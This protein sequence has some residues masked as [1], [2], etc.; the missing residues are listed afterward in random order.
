MSQC[1]H[2]P[3]P[4][5]YHRWPVFTLWCCSLPLCKLALK[6]STKVC[7]WGLRVIHSILHIY[8]ILTLEHR[9]FSCLWEYQWLLID[10]INSRHIKS[11]CNPNITVSSSL[12]HVLHSDVWNHNVHSL[13]SSGAYPLATHLCCHHEIWFLLDGRYELVVRQGVSPQ[14]ARAI[15]TTKNQGHSLHIFIDF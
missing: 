4:S 11:I 1:S 8:S 2:V 6:N 3:L 15:T 7:L 14:P 13:C 9:Y 10:Y 12:L 5:S